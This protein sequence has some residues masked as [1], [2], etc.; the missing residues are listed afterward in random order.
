MKPELREK[1]N[2]EKSW[3]F[4]ESTKN[5]NY[6]YQNLAFSWI[7]TEKDNWPPLVDLE[8]TFSVLMM[9]DERDISMSG[10]VPVEALNFR[11]GTKGLRL[12]ELYPEIVKRNM[13]LGEAL[14]IPEKE[15]WEYSMGVGW[16]C[17]TWVTAM[18]KNSGFFDGVTIE[19]TEFI[20]KDNYLLNFYETDAKILA[21]CQKLDP[22]LPYCQ[23]MGDVLFELPGFNTIKP[24]NHMNEKCPSLAPLYERTEGC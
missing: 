7:D 3:A 10:L 15:G 24:Y 20:P 12:K 9:L 2:V 14:A 21:E 11:L 18:W 16:V 4:F 19:A 5:L 22:E 8:F 23:V 6:G 17:S 13:S 1:F